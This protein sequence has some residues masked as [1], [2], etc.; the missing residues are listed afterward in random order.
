M[1]AVDA[2]AVVIV[3]RVVIGDVVLFILGNQ[4]IQRIYF[5]NINKLTSKK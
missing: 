3:V 2:L 4:Q 5:S 1:V